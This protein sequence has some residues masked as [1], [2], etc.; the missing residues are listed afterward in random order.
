MSNGLKLEVHA[1]FINLTK[2]YSFTFTISN[3]CNCEPSHNNFRVNLP[4]Y[5]ARIEKV[6]RL[7][8][9]SSDLT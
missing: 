8:A 4:L 3:N 1:L 6:T 9:G 7:C 2:V 5:S